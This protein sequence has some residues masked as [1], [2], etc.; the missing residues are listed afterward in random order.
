M[1]LS[2]QCARDT[3]KFIKLDFHR[4][5]IAASFVLIGAQVALSFAPFSQ[6]ILIAEFLLFLV[7]LFVLRSGLLDIA[8][9]GMKVVG[10]RRQ[11]S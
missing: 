8:R 7:L 4:G 10:S 3:R 1:P 2:L 9:K 11:S 5:E 6:G